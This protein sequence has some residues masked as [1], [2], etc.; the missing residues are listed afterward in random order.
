MKTK[1]IVKIQTNCLK[2]KCVKV[3]T[4]S[5]FDEASTETINLKSEDTILNGYCVKIKFPTTYSLKKDNI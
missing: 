4:N 2:R 5:D 3:V 1:L